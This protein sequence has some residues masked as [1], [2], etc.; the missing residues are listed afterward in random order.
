ML[1]TSGPWLIKSKDGYTVKAL[2]ILSGYSSVNRDVSVFWSRK[3]FDV[4][5]LNL[6]VWQTFLVA[7]LRLWF[8]HH[9]RNLVWLPGAPEGMPC[10][11]LGLMQCLQLSCLLP[12]ALPGSWGRSCSVLAQTCCMPLCFLGECELGKQLWKWVTTSH[13]M[14]LAY[15]LVAVRGVPAAWNHTW[16][17]YGLVLTAAMSWCSSDAH[18]G[19]RGVCCHPCWRCDSDSGA[20]CLVRR[21]TA[22]LTDNMQL[23][24][25]CAGFLFKIRLYVWSYWLGHEFSGSW[26][27]CL[28][29][30]WLST[31]DIRSLRSVSAGGAVGRLALCRSCACACPAHSSRSASEMVSQINT[32]MYLKTAKPGRLTVWWDWRENTNCCRNAAFFL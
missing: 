2:D 7:V 22:A 25:L 18:T 4:G 20:A 26:N 10:L 17:L 29:L 23:P 31:A 5:L 11:L 3:F 30:P 15:M 6:W 21:G 8:P 28:T 32:W 27:A 19:W 24:L 12:Q 14:T 9:T 16:L 1:T 13:G